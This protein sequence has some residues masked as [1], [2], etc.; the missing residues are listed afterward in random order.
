MKV[1]LSLYASR[2]KNVGG[3]CSTSDPFAVV[4]Q[5][6]TGSDA[7]PVVLGKTEVIENS[8]SPNWIKTFTFDYELGTP[9]KVA[10]SIYDKDKDDGENKSMGSVVFDI[11]ELLGC[12]GNTKAKKLKGNGT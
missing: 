5:I 1:E 7:K 3:I 10:V 11:G 9:M 4:T 2:L 12:R 8:L 6:A